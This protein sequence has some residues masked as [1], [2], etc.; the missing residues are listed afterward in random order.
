MLD[1]DPVPVRATTTTTMMI[2]VELNST[3]TRFHADLGDRPQLSQVVRPPPVAAKV[4]PCPSDDATRTLA[5][6]AV[7]AGTRR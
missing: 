7:P 6:L 2:N 1:S 5:C 3:S 4:A